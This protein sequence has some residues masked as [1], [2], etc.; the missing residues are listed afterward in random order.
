[1]R[2]L[3]ADFDVVPL[4]LCASHVNEVHGLRSHRE[5]AASKHVGGCQDEMSDSVVGSEQSDGGSAVMDRG[6]RSGVFAASICDV[7]VV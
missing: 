1:M 7:R 6:V 5:A 3:E 4:G 2:L